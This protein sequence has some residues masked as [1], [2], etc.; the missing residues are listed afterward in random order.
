MS[1]T[2]ESVKDFARKAGASLVKVADLDL[3]R[4]IYTDPED[5]LDGYARAVSM[6]VRL[7]DGVM[8]P[9]LDRPTPLYGRH[10]K[11]AND[12]L[13]RL[14][15]QVADLIEQGGGRALPLPASHTT[16]RE[17]LR[18]YLSHK[19]VA[20]AAGLGWQGKSLLTVS[21][22][23]GPRIRLV[24]VLTNLPLAPDER[25]KNRCGACT[26]CVDAC[27]AGAIRNVNTDWHYASRNEAVDLALCRDRLYD[28]H[29]S[30]PHIDAPICGVCIR[31][32]PWGRPKKARR[33]H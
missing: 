3:L 7:S 22:E 14:A 20:V 5:L 4:G 15:L 13:D 12:L 17:N 16:D 28:V 6:A 18:S 31:A 2:A 26:A 24:T 27:P 30:L 33:A 32:C 8:D 23:F 21:P 9:I 19:A 29:M 11:I 10:Y 1:V 25:L